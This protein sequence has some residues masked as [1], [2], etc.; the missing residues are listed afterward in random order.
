MIIAGWVIGGAPN[1]DPQLL[2]K[3]KLPI[4]DAS[5]NEHLQD[6]AVVTDRSV[7]QSPLRIAAIRPLVDTTISSA[8]ITAT[9]PDGRVEPLLWLYRYDGRSGQTFQFREPVDLP[10]RTVIASSAPLRFALETAA[11]DSSRAQ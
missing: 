8:R 11:T 4:R 7:L 10:Q 1:G 9:L 2:P 6:A 3:G 5:I